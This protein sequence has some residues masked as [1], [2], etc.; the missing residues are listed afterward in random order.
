MVAPVDDP[1]AAAGLIVGGL[2]ATV[3]VGATIVLGPH[4]GWLGTLLAQPAAWSAPLA[5][6]T[7]VGVSLAT[8]ARTPRHT[9]RTLA[10]LHTPESVLSS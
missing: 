2:T 6:A 8:P 9:G 4:H 10:R 7:T 1:G 5:F 3:S